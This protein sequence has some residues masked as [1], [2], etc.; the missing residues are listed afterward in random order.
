MKG[1]FAIGL[2]SILSSSALFAG[3]CD[4][5]SNYN[6]KNG[7]RSVY[8][9][10]A[11]TS[12]YSKN[13]VVCIDSDVPSF[14]STASTNAINRLNSNLGSINT[15]LRFSSSTKNCV[16]KIKLS[17]TLSS[18]LYAL[19]Q[20]AVDPGKMVVYINA[21]FTELA[22]KPLAEYVIMHELL[23]TVGFFHTGQS[24]YYE[25][26]KTDGYYDTLYAGSSIMCGVSNESSPTRA[27]NFLDKRAI[28][29]IYPK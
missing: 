5:D 16:A 23:H 7:H 25:V 22:S 4:F 13:V 19:A 14:W 3:E 24:Q 8:P 26:P 9:Q 29:T 27:F 15:K 6:Y 12:T 2:I 20:N 18:S 10:N 11:L 21:N 1:I 28:E 17:Y